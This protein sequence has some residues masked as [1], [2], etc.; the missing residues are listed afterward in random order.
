MEESGEKKE[1]SS[2]VDFVKWFSELGKDSGNVAGG[3]GA[4]LGEM[5]NNK[6][7]VPNGFVVTAQAYDYFIEEAQL[8]DKIKSLLDTIDYENSAELDRITTQIRKIILDSEFPEDIKE[9]I[10]DSY[11]HLGTSKVEIERG[12]A[13]D[14]LNSAAEPVF[15]AVRS[16]ATTED[17]A[18]AS[19]AGQQDTYVNIKGNEELLKHVKKCFASLFTA[20]ATYYRNKKGFVHEKSSLAVVVQKM[21]HSEK[22]GVIFSKDPNYGGDD[23]IIEAVWGLG[24]GIVS[25]RITPDHYVI[26]RELEIL[27]KKVEEKKIAIVRDSSGKTGII[28]LQESKSKY[29]VLKDY[30]IKRLADL[31]IKIETHY[32]KPQDL[33][34]A[35][36]GED[37]F[38]VQTRPIT[39][40]EKKIERQDTKIEGEVLLSGQAASPGVASGIVRVVHDLAEL[41][42]IKEGDILVT[43]MTN[44]DMV[45]SMQKS[46]AIITDEGG[47]TA[48]AAI[49]SREMGIPCVV[50][51]RTATE[52]LK[53]GDLV[54][55]D[56]YGGKIYRG[57]TAETEKK[58][59]A[60]VN[61]DT[62]TKI[63]VIVDLPSFAERASKTGLKQ[64]GLTRIEGII[65]ESGKH[66]N[67]FLQ[68]G[69][70]KPYEEIIFKGI[71]EITNYFDEV[72]VRTSD[73]RTDEFHNLEGAPEEIEANPMLGMHGIRFSLKNPAILKAE[74]NALKRISDKGKTVG[75]LMPQVILLEELQGVK[76]VLAEI[77]FDKCKVGIM[78]ETP[79]AV[80]LIKDF[81]EDGIDFIS[82]GTNDLTQ[83]ILAVDRGNEE[84]QNLFDEM[85][86]AVLYQLGY[87][88]R[89]CKRYN[90]E[91]SIC[92]Q[93]GS[94]KEM[95]KFLV[96]NG[97]DSISVN[98]DVAKDISD[99]V[100]ELEGNKIKG[101]DKEP[102]QYEVKKAEL[103][104][105]EE[106][107]LESQDEKEELVTEE[108][109][110]DEPVFSEEALEDS[111]EDKE[112]VEEDIEAIEEEKEEFENQEENPVTPS[113]TVEE[114]EVVEETPV[115]ETPIEEPEDGREEVEGEIPGESDL[116]KGDEAVE[117]IEEEK[118]EYLEEHSEN[119]EEFGEKDEVGEKDPLGIF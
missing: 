93:S 72:W 56:G 10:L 55:V 51:T 110:K 88:I 4:N 114:P 57:K 83:Y 64:V 82:F 32:E 87:V 97:I 60:L 58:E 65:A 7:P 94:R 76:K 108:V 34:F 86:P 59:I 21:V 103:Q 27:D 66:P 80:Q 92:G 78:I 16:S 111:V 28:K 33:E 6:I 116:V 41:S 119:V 5:Y 106:V 3:K 8:K 95:V 61:A 105:K 91:T 69:D 53:D 77:G 109:T 2:N 75:I 30:E 38:I 42:K 45:V 99:Y 39:T 15:V 98:A 62:K 67:Y 29:Q 49:V 112:Q 23:V 84:V 100:S 118:K 117:A 9:E 71:S 37:I 19:F 22:S 101:T 40:L 74:L 35:I 26:S 104:R 96:E 113:D 68:K 36:E 50:G 11:E 48:H 20:R 24:E 81:C 115:E 44:P 14:I 47:L 63:K 17:L 73:I 70:I 90:V 79:A 102:R 52:N 1:I 43:G 13:M 31:A 89:V 46:A 85:H 18:D 25:G 12:S 54:T 107:S